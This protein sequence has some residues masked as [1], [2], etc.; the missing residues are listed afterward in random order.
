MGPIL[1]NRAA[2]AFFPSSL[3]FNAAQSN[4]EESRWVGGGGRRRFGLGRSQRGLSIFFSFC[5]SAFAVFAI[6]S[7]ML[8][9]FITQLFGKKAESVYWLSRRTAARSALCVG[10]ALCYAMRL[11]QTRINLK[12][13][14][15]FPLSISPKK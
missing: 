6:F 14:A 13:S 4:Q 2:G 15:I 11:M 5:R 9:L 8:P 10:G 7:L 3:L 1:L 12:P